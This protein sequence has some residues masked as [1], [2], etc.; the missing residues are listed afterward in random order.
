MTISNIDGMLEAFNLFDNVN[1]GSYTTRESN[2]S[3]GR[4]SFNNNI[5]YAPRMLQ[6]GFR[7]A[8]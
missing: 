8:F 7:L 5:A 4:P 1:Y 2:A 3:F 6:L